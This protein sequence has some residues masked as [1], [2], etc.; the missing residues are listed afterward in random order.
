MIDILFI[1][2]YCQNIDFKVG[3][4]ET[5]TIR[6]VDRGYVKPIPSFTDRLAGLTKGSFGQTGDEIQKWLDRERKER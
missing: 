4:M 5:R 3:I 1:I 6:V 2:D